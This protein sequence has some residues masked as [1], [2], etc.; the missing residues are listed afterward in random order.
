[1]L[2]DNLYLDPL[3]SSAVAILSIDERARTISIVKQK[4]ADERKRM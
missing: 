3:S 1:M 2:E 4:G